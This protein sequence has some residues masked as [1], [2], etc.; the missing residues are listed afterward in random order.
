MCIDTF[1][2]FLRDTYLTLIEL[3]LSKFSKFCLL[4]IVRSYDY[5]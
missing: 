4:L 2:L 3:T 5:V 1:I